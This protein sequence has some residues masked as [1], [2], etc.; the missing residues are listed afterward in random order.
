MKSELGRLSTYFPR[1]RFVLSA[2]LALSACCASVCGVLSAGHGIALA[3]ARMQNIVAAAKP[4][5]PS[6]AVTTS[7]VGL[8]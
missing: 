5:A 3:S 1:H 4:T 8:T 7:V 2:A 6:S